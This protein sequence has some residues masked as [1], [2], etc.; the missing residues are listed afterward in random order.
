[1]LALGNCEEINRTGLVRG[2]LA[3]F[4]GLDFELSGDGVACDRIVKA[5]PPRVPGGAGLT[6]GASHRVGA[7]TLA[8]KFAARCRLHMLGT[9]G[10]ERPI[11]PRPGITWRWGAGGGH[12]VT[13]FA[14]ACISGGASA[15][16]GRA[17]VDEDAL[18]PHFLLSGLTALL[19]HRLGGAILHAAS[20]E[21]DSGVVAFIGPSGAGKSTA[22]R[23]VEHAPLFSVDRLA[24]V[25]LGVAGSAQAG[26]LWLSHPLPGGTRPVPDMRSAEPRWLPLAGILRVERSPADTAIAVPSLAGAV[27]SLRESTFQAGVG[28]GVEAELLGT[29]EYLAQRLPVA[30]L[31]LSLGASLG[32]LLRRWLV[33]QGEERR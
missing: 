19:V 1:V 29:L 20:V 8:P 15:F 25:P 13:R 10:A 21:V 5:A 32:P 16:S 30:R 6:V 18:A 23:H 11:L 3:S 26:P 4:A 33:D 7:N 24:I 27:T 22:C 31:Q 28:P 12:V 17:W 14:H 2:V 9:E